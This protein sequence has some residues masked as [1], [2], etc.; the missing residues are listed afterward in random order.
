MRGVHQLSELHYVICLQS[1]NRTDGALVLIHCVL[2][3]LSADITL[4][5]SGELLKGRL[6]QITECLDFYYLL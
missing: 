1:L 5:N 3:T 4:D 2:C 6:I